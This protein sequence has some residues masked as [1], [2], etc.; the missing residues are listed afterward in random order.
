MRRK[1]VLGT[2][3]SVMLSAV[4]WAQSPQ[5]QPARGPVELRVDNLKTPL[6][7]DDPAPRF[8]WQLRDSARGARQDGI[9]IDGGLDHCG[10]DAR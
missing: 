2:V 4:V 7:I 3:L 10:A 9:R 1:F 6:G 8:S 5:G